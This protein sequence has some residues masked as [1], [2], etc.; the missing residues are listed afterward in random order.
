MIMIIIFIVLEILIRLWTILILLII[1]NKTQGGSLQ[2][3]FPPFKT[4]AVYFSIFVY[5]FGSYDAFGGTSN[6]LSLAGIITIHTLH[7]LDP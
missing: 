2:A 3:P 4:E 6:K 5:L 1:T 7:L